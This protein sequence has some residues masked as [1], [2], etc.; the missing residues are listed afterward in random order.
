MSLRGSA[1]LLAGKTRDSDHSDLAV[2]PWLLRDP[3]DE[4][5]VVRILVAI[6]PFRLGRAPRLRDHMNV[7]VGDETPGVARLDGT[8]PERSVGGLRRQDIRD[9]G[10]LNVL[11]MQGRGIEHGIL[12]GPVR[13]IDVH[14]QAR[15][16]SH[17]YTDVSFLD[18]QLGSAH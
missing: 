3:V 1:P 16:I 7:A 10:T 14:R 5:V 8:E 2:R 9:V 12:A 17:G 6:M 18:H 4:I 15:A 11:V 13:S